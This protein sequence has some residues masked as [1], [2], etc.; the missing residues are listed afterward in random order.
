MVLVNL[1]AIIVTHIV[2]I[3][4]KKLLLV[5]SSWPLNEVIK[6]AFQVNNKTTRKRHQNMTSDAKIVYNEFDGF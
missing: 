1:N 2:E 3:F 4:S 6:Q 5:K